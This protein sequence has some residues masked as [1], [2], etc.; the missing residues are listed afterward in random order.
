MARNKRNQKR[1]KAIQ[2]KEQNMETFAESNKDTESKPPKTGECGVCAG[3]DL[4]KDFMELGQANYNTVGGSSEDLV[5]KVEEMKNADPDFFG[6]LQ[7]RTLS[8]LSLERVIVG[9]GPEADFVREVFSRFENFHGTFFEI[10]SAV[11]LGYS[12]TELVWEEENGKYIIDKLLVRYQEKFMFT[13]T[14]ELRI[15]DPDSTEGIPTHPK[16]FAVMTFQGKYGN[17][18]GNGLAKRVYWY[19]YFKKYGLKFWNIFTEKFANPWVVATGV[20]S[21]D[22][23]EQIDNFMEDLATMTGVRVSEGVVLELLQAKQSGVDTF[24]KLIDYLNRAIAVAIL[25]QAS[26]ITS[27]QKGGSYASDKVREAITRGDILGSDILM[28]ENF[29]NDQPIKWLVDANFNTGNYPK[30]RIIQKEDVDKKLMA[31]VVEILSR[32]F[33]NLDI[34]KKWGKELFS[35][36]EVEEGDKVLKVRDNAPALFSEKFQSAEHEILM[37]E[38]KDLDNGAE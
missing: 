30:L 7:T 23:A 1:K 28:C 22:D 32:T 21:A 24:E 35:I 11:S 12:V 14:G 25:G 3:E 10:L 17:R 34:P 18:Y 6:L 9:E 20:N 2:K 8:I 38:L 36:P 19:W 27:G 31:E 29:F 15:K 4:Y 16:K 13:E 37:G 26:S 33:S 5:Q